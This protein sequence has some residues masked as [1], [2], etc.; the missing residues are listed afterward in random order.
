[1]RS[2]LIVTAGGALILAG[3]GA[4][5]QGRRT[6]SPDAPPGPLYEGNGLVMEHPDG[7]VVICF[8]STTDTIPPQCGTTVPMQNWDW[9]GVDDEEKASGTTWGFYHLVGVYDGHSFSVVEWGSHEPPYYGISP[10]PGTPCPEPEGGWPSTS[11]E[12]GREGL[13]T[14]YLAAQ[15]EPDYGGGWG[16]HPYEVPDGPR[17]PVVLNVSFTSD[18]E[19]HRRELEGLWKGPLCVSRASHK[20]DELRRIQRRLSW[21][22]LE[23][24]GLISLDSWIEEYR[25]RVVIGAVITDPEVEAILAEKYGEGTVL[26]EP[27][28]VRVP[29]T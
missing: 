6:Q 28:L 18:L 15:E 24:L 26:V 29:G 17:G 5:L 3:C 19:R 1:V 4:A 9:G 23:E 7:D 27:A 16:D 8:G 13:H 11:F 12:G 14:A 2:T 20:L 25:N 10:S 21:G 22:G